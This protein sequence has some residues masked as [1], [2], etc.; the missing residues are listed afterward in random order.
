MGVTTDQG[1]GVV[2]NTTSLALNG[3]VTVL[4]PKPHAYVYAERRTAVQEKL[5]PEATRVCVC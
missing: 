1:D 3:M 5:G 2:A 4:V